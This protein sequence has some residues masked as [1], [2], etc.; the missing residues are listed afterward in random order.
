MAHL[1]K[2]GY[3]LSLLFVYIYG[4]FKKCDDFYSLVSI[5]IHGPFKKLAIFSLLSVY[6]M[7]STTLQ[8]EYS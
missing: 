7:R 3:I 1:K 2:C 6:S 4:A 5:Y 8:N